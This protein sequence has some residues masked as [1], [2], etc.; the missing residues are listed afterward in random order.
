MPWLEVRPM[1]AKILFISDWIRMRAHTGFSELCEKHG[2]SRKTG[3]KWVGRY[4]EAGIE[5]LQDRSR[6]PDRS[7]NKVSYTIQKEIIAVRK[8][9]KRWGSRKINKILENKHPDWDIPSYHTIHKILKEADLLSPQ[10]RR[11]R[12]PVH[13]G[14]LEGAKQPNDLWT[15]DFK[16]QF[17]TWD[18]VYCYPLTVMDQASRYLYD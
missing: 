3:Y 4:E 5:G 14:P 2:I 7:P 1:D 11:K 12:V 8:K 15:V 16:G 13:P 17:K 6:R 9:H 10:Q 18:G